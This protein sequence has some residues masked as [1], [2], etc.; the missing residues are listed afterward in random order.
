MSDD[1]WTKEDTGWSLGAFSL[2][3]FA[4]PNSSVFF[5]IEHKNE[6]CYLYVDRPDTISEKPAA[7]INR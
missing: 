5:C 4:A 6:S 1:K 7:E 2:Y 3:N